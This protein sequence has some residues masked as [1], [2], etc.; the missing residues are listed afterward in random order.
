MRSAKRP[1]EQRM[2][3]LNE[4]LVPT[5][6][7]PAS[8]ETFAQARAFV[9]GANP[10]VILVHVIDPVLVDAA[11]AAG[12]GTAAEVS[13]KLRERAERELAKMAESAD[14]IEVVQVVAEGVPF[15]EIARHAEEFAVDA[16]I[17]AKTGTGDA[18]EDLFFGSTAEKVVRAC[19]PPVIVLTYT[20]GPES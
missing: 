15:Y 3:E 13:A 1:S 6:F 12:F 5:D 8:R 7:S 14:G 2:L 9:T 4:V 19:R 17:I 10:A 16:V 20:A 11:S 18:R